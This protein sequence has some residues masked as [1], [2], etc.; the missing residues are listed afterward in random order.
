[1][2]AGLVARA[3]RLGHELALERVE[4]VEE[5]DGEAA[6]RAEP[7]VGRHVGDAETSSIPLPDARHPERLAED[8]VLDLVDR[9]DGLGLRVREADRVVEAAVGA[10]EDV[11]VD[12][13]GDEEA[14][15]LVRVAGEVGSASAEG[16]ADRGAGDDHEPSR[17]EVRLR[18]L[19]EPRTVVRERFESRFERGEP[20]GRADFEEPAHEPR[21]LASASPPRAGSG[22]R[23]DRAARRAGARR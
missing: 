8:A 13:G 6:R 9:L 20:F 4:R 10:D 21:P 12:R 15:V 5:R 11:L 23:R 2:L 18:V 14:A 1:M 19:R 3:A 22:W 16:E 17:V 7:D